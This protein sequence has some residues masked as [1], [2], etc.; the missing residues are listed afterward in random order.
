MEP[1]PQ[2]RRSFSRALALLE[3]TVSH[4]SAYERQLLAGYQRGEQTLEQIAGLLETSPY[5][6][7]YHSQATPLPSLPHLRD[8]LLH[9][10]HYN[11]E[12]NITGLLLCSEGHFVQL[13]EGAEADV[14]ALFTLI[15]TDRRHKQ[16]QMVSQGAVR[17]RHFAQWNMGFGQVAASAL[18]QLIRA[19]QDRLPLH[20]LHF[21]DSC[22][23]AL[24]QASA[25]GDVK[26]P[27]PSPTKK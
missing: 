5:Q 20:K 9:S 8:I 10:Q 24:W 26:L 16:I 23:Q 27:F 14:Q 22:L 11:A 21:N 17:Q 3:H 25:D 6:L 19:V 13:L 1:S 2:H 15:K 7:L 18:A 12:H 4:P